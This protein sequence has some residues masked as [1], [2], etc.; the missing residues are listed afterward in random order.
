MKRSLLLLPILL[1]V[2]LFAACSSPGLPVSETPGAE[3][4]VAGEP[5]LPLDDFPA[6]VNAARQA[7]AGRMG[8]SVDQINVA[9]YSQADWPD[10]CLGLGGPAESC[11]AVITPGFEVRLE[12]DGEQYFYRTD[13][14]GAAVRPDSFVVS[15]AAADLA[16]A[17]LAE[18]LGSTIDEVVVVSHVAVD[19]PDGCLGLP[20]P[21][22]LCAMMIVPG[23]EITLRVGDELYVF[24]TNEDGTQVR[25]APLLPASE[26]TGIILSER[27]GIGPAQ[28]ELVSEEGVDWP[29]ACL[30]VHL[31]DRMCAE[32][33]TPGYRFIFTV[34]GDEYVVHTNQAVSAFALASAPLPLA[35]DAQIVWEERD[36][37]CSTVLVSQKALAYGRCEG[38]LAPAF[39]AS[40]E[41]V[42]EL[43]YLLRAF[44]PFAADTAAGKVIFRGIGQQEAGE[45]ERRAVAE[46][47]QQ[48]FRD[49]RE[50]QSDA[51]AGLVLEWR[52]EGGFAGFCD[53]LRVSASGFAASY[54]CHG[55]TRAGMAF[56]ARE[57][58]EQ[59]YEWRD[60]LMPLEI[61]E[62]DDAVTDAMIIRLLFH[63]NGLRP[64]SEQEEQAM[65]SMAHQIFNQTG[66]TQ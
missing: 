12:L 23:F 17:T 54:G 39:F 51:A 44:A 43:D 62:K 38:E 4:P 32:V 45:A 31:P 52:R 63:G 26:K 20:A 18:R 29:D 19:W 59:L 30:G 22:E 55:N 35:E 15:S 58:L 5:V 9:S 41:R 47:A 37:G 57:Q 8:V 61:E 56:L 6:A 24:R 34:A 28:I 66:Q 33:I 1:L 21:D 48:A 49:A 53:T 16:R 27:T 64:A 11:L 10:G 65:L 3:T 46:W 25:E 40:L 50:H 13:L 7:L 14:E 42:D 36:L 2:L 60:N